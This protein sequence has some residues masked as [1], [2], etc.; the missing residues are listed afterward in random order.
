[1]VRLY[2][3]W[4]MPAKADEWKAKL[5]LRDLPANVFSPSAGR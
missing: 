4:D 5:G 1:V 3:L 2:E